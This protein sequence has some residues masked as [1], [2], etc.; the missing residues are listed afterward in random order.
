MLGAAP[1]CKRYRGLA[2][3]Y[4]IL[5]LA[6]AAQLAFAANALAAPPRNQH[7]TRPTRVWGIALDGRQSDEPNLE[8]LSQAKAAGLNAIVTDPKRWSP[9]RHTRLVELARQL[10]LLL[11]EPQRPALGSADRELTADRCKAQRSLHRPCAV[12]AT[13][14]TEASLFARHTNADYVVVRLDSPAD[15]ARLNAR[16]AGPQMIGILTVGATPKLDATW[17]R[18]V[19]K[20]SGDNRSTIAVGLSGS[21]AAAAMQN[22]FTLL[23]KHSVTTRTFDARQGSGGPDRLPPTTPLGGTVASAT[24]TTVNLSW[25]A[26]TD[27]VGVAGYGVYV[28]GSLV[29]STAATAFTVTGLVCGSTYTF[30]VDAYDKRK[31]RSTK[32]IFTGSTAGCPAPPPSSQQSDTT[33]P[34]QPSALTTTGV[35]TSSITLTWGSSTDNV[36]VTGYEV[37]KGGVVAGNTSA[38][39]YLLSGLSCGTSY[40]L[41]VKA[42]DAAGNKSQA[43][44]ITVPTSACAAPADTTAPTTPGNFHVTSTTVGSISVA[45][46]PSTDNVGVTGYGVYRD[47]ALDGSTNS[48]AYTISGLACG[49]TYILALDAYDAAGNHSARATLTTSTSACPPA[50]DT[51]APSTPTAVHAT[52]ATPTSVTIAWTASTDNVGVAGYTAYDETATAGTTTSTSYTI[53]GLLC[54]ATYNLSVDAFDA[55]GNRSSKATISSTTNACAAPP[56]PADTQAPTTPTNLA[57]ISATTTSITVGWSASSDNVGVTGYGLYRGGSST[58]STTSTSATFSGLS[59]GSAYVLAV[60]AYDAAGNR[61]NQATITASASPCPP[62]SDTQAPTVPGSLHVTGATGSSITVAWTASTDNVGVSGYG[63]YRAGSSTG[64]TTT[65]S[66]TFSGLACGTTYTLGVD[67]YDAAGNRSAQA[68]VSSPTSACPPPPPTTDTTAPT[69]PGNLATT[70]ATTTSISVSW[71]ASTDNVGVTGYGLYRG[72]TSTGSTT[73]TSAS[74]TGLTCGTAY[75]LAVDAYDAAGNRS[76]KSSITASTSACPPPADTQAPT[77]PGAL[78]ATAATTSSITI[79][80]SASTDNVGVTGYGLYRNSTST[81][82]TA[83]TSASFSGLSCGTAYTLAV[84]AYDA[85]GNRSAKASITASTSACPP[86]ADTQ[87]PTAPGGFHATGATAN[88]VTVAWTASTD[89]VGVTGYTVYNGSSTAGSTT[90]TSYAVSGLACGTSYTLAVDAYDAAGNRSGKAT[91]SASTAACSA[92]APPPTSGSANL[93]V[94]PSGGSCTRSATASAYV[95][96]AACSSLDAAFDAASSG[97]TILVKAGNYSGAITGYNKTSYV[98]ISPASGET[99]TVSGFSI[100][101][102]YV[103]LTGIKFQS[104]AGDVDITSSGGSR[105]T[106]RTNHVQLI[107]FGSGRSGFVTADDVLL[108]NGSLGGFDACTAGGSGGIEDILQLWDDGSI[109]SQRVTL[110]G[111]TL[112]NLT[113]STPGCHGFHSDCL[114]SLDGNDIVVTNTV[115]TSCYGEDVI[116]RAYLTTGVGPLTIE[117][118]SLGASSTSENSTLCNAGDSCAGNFVLRNNTINTQIGHFGG[119]T[120]TFTGNVCKVSATDCVPGEGGTK[121]VSYN[122]FASGSTG[123]NAVTCMPA[124]LS[125]GYHLSSSDTCAKGR[126]NPSSYPATDID[127]GARPQGGSVPDAGADEVG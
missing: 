61:S 59:C 73:S 64:S 72:G 106:N 100:Q 121:N 111:L 122:T 51:A 71:S 9:S 80:W 116:I 42:Y 45:W 16:S 31:N 35:T 10:G 4:A 104:T 30:G 1:T 91:V 101:A 83:S 58:G 120:L 102:Q 6:L 88:S 84:D 67:A 124:F 47:G 125:D 34:T 17:D 3:R 22:Y 81:G 87:A 20:A 94:D 46:N 97:D 50:T 117:N 52:G 105:T 8:L 110:D 43:A 103:R 18:A 62:A 126:G 55:A 39:S 60:D 48:T 78:S 92:P 37:S 95:D 57:V 25:I 119:T 27:N 90:A 74:F 99:V 85:A 14:A 11:I 69:V 75:T 28:N 127:G 54:G 108:K 123:T 114:Q 113:Q 36:G 7:N 15:L 32:L 38:T 86:P 115:F 76:G 40:S 53:S 2:F 49:G 109:D 79:G 107:D 77:T 56:P 23:D 29:G 63:L 13:S 24:T 70:G 82:S 89:N 21:F 66:A 19:T 98:S 5:A 26:S 12:V 33:P 65:T 118:S 96:S 44:S 112:H 68:T 41:S 93:W